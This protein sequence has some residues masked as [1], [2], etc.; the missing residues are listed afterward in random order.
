M[1]SGRNDLPKQHPLLSIEALQLHLLDGRV[2]VRPGVDP[3]SGDE[4]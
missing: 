4:Y 2:V 3:N 1:S